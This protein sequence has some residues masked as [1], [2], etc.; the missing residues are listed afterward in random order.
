MKFEINLTKS[1]L[2]Y[3]HHECQWHGWFSPPLTFTPLQPLPPI[4]P[5]MEGAKCTNE[6][7]LFLLRYVLQLSL[8]TSYN[9][10][11]ALIPL[12]TAKSS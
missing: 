9:S 4:C 6:P 2:Q 8:I 10:L 7:L 1:N 12:T 5:P 11:F 3:H